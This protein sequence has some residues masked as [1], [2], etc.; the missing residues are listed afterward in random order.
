MVYVGHRSRKILE[1][2]VE[3]ISTLEETHMA[4]AMVVMERPNPSISHEA[5][6][7]VQGLSNEPGVFCMGESAWIFDTTKA[8]VRFGL[9]IAQASERGLQLYVFHLH[10]NSFRLHATSYP[11]S[12]RLQD[13]LNS[14]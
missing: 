14:D 6:S 12:Q 1:R 9:L 7:E 13:F 10:D 3:L 5:L 8:I 4:Y 11:R 2:C